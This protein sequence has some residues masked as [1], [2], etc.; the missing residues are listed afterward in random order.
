MGMTEAATDMFQSNLTLNLLQNPRR[1]LPSDQSTYPSLRATRANR[2]QQIFWS[3]LNELL[4]NEDT[5]FAY[6]VT[7]M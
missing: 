1:K 5:Y 2:S 7:V 4:W 3:R 6:S